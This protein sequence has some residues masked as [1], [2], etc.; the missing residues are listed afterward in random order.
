MNIE[1]IEECSYN[2]NFKFYTIKI[3]IKYN[4]NNDIDYG[5]ELYNFKKV[6]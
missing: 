5:I 2:E 4:N 1:N 6:L 3:P